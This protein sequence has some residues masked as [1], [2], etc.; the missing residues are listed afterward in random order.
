MHM[1][2]DNLPDIGVG[3][4][5]RDEGAVVQHFDIICRDMQRI[6]VVVQHHDHRQIRG[7]SQPRARSQSS[8]A[9]VR[10]PSTRPGSDESSTITR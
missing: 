5:H 7:F 10:T 1:T 6:G 4:Q 8:C 3:F 9:V 2:R